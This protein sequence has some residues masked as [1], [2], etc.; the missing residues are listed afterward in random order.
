MTNVGRNLAWHRMYTAAPTDSA[1]TQ[2][3]CGT[4]VIPPAVTD[5]ALGTPIG[6]PANFVAGYPAFDTTNQEVMTRGFISSV[7]LNGNNISEVGEFNTD[8]APVM[9][10]R[11]TFTA[12]AKTNLIEIAFLWVHCLE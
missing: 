1:I 12:I 8:G 9:S 5:T 4:G 7:D 10:S 2:F 6:V 3:Q 11:A